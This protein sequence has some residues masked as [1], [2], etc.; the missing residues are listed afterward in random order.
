MDEYT[1][2]NFIEKGHFLFPLTFDSNLTEWNVQT[3]SHRF[4]TIDILKEKYSEDVN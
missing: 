4:Y 2:S 1:I 3:Q